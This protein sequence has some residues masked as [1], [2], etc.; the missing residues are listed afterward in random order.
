MAFKVDYQKV[1]TK[2]PTS[3]G[4][5]K[6]VMDGLDPSGK[7][8][9]PPDRDRPVLQESNKPSQKTT[10]QLEK[11]TD[12]TIDSQQHTRK[13]VEDG[14]AEQDHDHESTTEQIPR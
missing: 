11:K 1:T 3:E 6:Q 7:R 2:L 10:A 4:S 5:K 8:E 13:T 9:K 14:L 12:R